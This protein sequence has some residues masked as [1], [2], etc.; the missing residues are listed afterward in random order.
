MRS[1]QDEKTEPA[2]SCQAVSILAIDRGPCRRRFANPPKKREGMDNRF[3]MEISRACAASWQSLATTRRYQE[4]DKVKS[5][6]QQ[7]YRSSVATIRSLSSA[8]SLGEW[9]SDG[10]IAER[11]YRYC[12]RRHQAARRP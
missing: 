11:A 10:S 5:L 6:E 7:P 2:R 1:L 8:V 3:V 12:K 9:N 4:A